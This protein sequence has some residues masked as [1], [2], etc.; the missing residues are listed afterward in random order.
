MKFRKIIFAAAAVVAGMSFAAN[1]EVHSNAI[2]LRF[3]G[4]EINYQLGMGAANRLEAGL[5]WSSGS[6]GGGYWDNWGNWHY[7]NRW[8]HTSIGVFGAY[9]WHWNISPSAARGGFNWYAGPGAGVG[10]WS[11]RARNPN[12][13]YYDEHSGVSVSVGGQIGIEYDFNVLGAPILVDFDLRPTI[14]I[15]GGGFGLGPGL[16]VRYTF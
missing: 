7:G 14:G 15:P 2:G 1:A 9:Q 5:W 13:S 3:G 10:F 11:N 8:T 12:G 16:G 4:L 6:G